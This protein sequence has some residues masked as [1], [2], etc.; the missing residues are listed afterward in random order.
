[1][2]KFQDLKPYIKQLG[3][4]DKLCIFSKRT[5]VLLD[6]IYINPN[7]RKLY[8][9]H[10]ILCSHE[11][12]ENEDRYY[13]F[14]HIRKEDSYF[15]VLNIEDWTSY[16]RKRNYDEYMRALEDKA[17]NNAKLILED[18]KKDQGKYVFFTFQSGRDEKYEGFL[19]SVVASDED[20]YFVYLT[21]DNRLRLITCVSGY[22]VIEDEEHKMVFTDKEIGIM[23]YDRFDCE[24]STDAV[25]YRGK[26]EV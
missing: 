26:Y 19:I 17:E 3:R 18:I 13:F 24:S 11:I 1:M 12:R 10:N 7:D 2:I 23:L 25:I 21:N 15:C 8:E 16:K 4:Y 6:T 22:K 20:Y 9:Y 14:E 5:H